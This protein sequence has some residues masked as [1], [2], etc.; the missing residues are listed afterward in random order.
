MK[1]ELYSLEMF[2]SK[3]LRWGVLLAGL[4]LLIGWLM[5][6]SLTG[7]PFAIFQTYHEVPFLETLQAVFTNR[8]WGLG[9]AYLG[10][11]ILISLPMLRVLMTAVLFFKQ[12]EYW[13][14]SAAT[15]VMIAL[16]ISF[17]LG[18]EI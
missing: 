11:C 14:A 16:L 15:L 18:F 3:L 7:N 4:F 6:I 13:M 12:K 10:L 2:I 1:D 17:S 9:L 5:N 8:E